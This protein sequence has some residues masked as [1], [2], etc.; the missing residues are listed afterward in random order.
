MEEKAGKYLNYPVLL[1]H[2]MGFRDNQTINYWGRIPNELEKLGCTIF[3]GNQDSNADAETNGRIIARRIDEII[4]TTGTEKVNIIAHSKGGLDCRYAISS[5]G[6]GDKVASLTTISTPHHGSKT[7]DLLMRLPKPLIKFVGFCTDCWFRLIGDNSPN[8]YQVFDSFTT[9]S[10]RA[11][12]LANPD[13]ERVYYQS[14]AFVMKSPF[15]DVLMW[16][17]RLVVG[18]IEGE[19]DG[20]LTPEAAKWSNFRG[21]YLGVGRRGISHCDEVDLRR[22]RF[23]KHTG[24]GVS[25][26]IDVYRSI[27]DDLRERGF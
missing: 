27:I 26:I 9:A 20:L 6:I 4:A 13:D 5:L 17:P 12:N 25:D 16:F 19:N 18:L 10:A 1:V 2:G 11:F 3:Y 15:S 7:V 22:R 21:V 24:E 8:S 14:Y 23:S